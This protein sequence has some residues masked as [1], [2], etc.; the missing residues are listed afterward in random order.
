[1]VVLSI[2][3]SHKLI[4]SDAVKNLKVGKSEFD[5]AIKKLISTPPIRA[6]KAAAKQHRA[7]RRK[8]SR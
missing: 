3:M 4:V 8:P 6:P 5:A 7:V 1:M 2:T